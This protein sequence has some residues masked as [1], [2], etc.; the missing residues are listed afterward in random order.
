MKALMKPFIKRGRGTKQ[1]APYL[2]RHLDAEEIAN[3]LIETL[4]KTEAGISVTDLGVLVL[5]FVTWFM[6]ESVLARVDAEVVAGVEPRVGVEHESTEKPYSS[7]WLRSIGAADHETSTYAAN[8]LETTIDM[9]VSGPILRAKVRQKFRNTTQ[10]W[11]EGIYTFPLP[12]Q[13]AVDRL[14][15]VVGERVIE[16]QIHEKQ[17]AQRI[18]QKAR[19]TGKKTSLLSHHRSNI[20]TTSIA[21]ISPG[22]EVIVE[23]EY[24]QLLDFKDNRYALRFPMV[25]TP[26]YTP[27]R[28]R[29]DTEF[30]APLNVIRS[31][32]EAPGNPVTITVDLKAGF[33]IETLTSTSHTFKKDKLSEAHYKVSLAGRAQDS[34]RD[35]V[36]SWKL[37][38]SAEPMVR[39]LR[40]DVEGESY[41]LLMLMP[42]QLSGGPPN[43]EGSH[44]EE[45]EN[46][47]NE[48]EENSSE[49]RDRINR[50]LILV[51]DVS[52]SM[53]GESIEQARSAMLKAVSQLRPEDHFNIIYFNTRSWQLFP[54]SL[55][56]QESNLNFA[57]RSI[58]DQS[59]DGGT[60][61]RP[62][63]Q[64]GL[65]VAR[66]SERL[67]QVIFITDG[68]V[69][70]ETDL[71][72]EIK[73]HLGDSRLF[74]VGIGSAPNS[75]FMRKAALAG[76]GTFTYVSQAKDVSHKMN[77]LFR[78]LASPALTDLGFDINDPS[79]S[80]LPQ[81][82]PDLYLGEPVYVAFKSRNFPKFAELS[83]KLDG[84]PSSLRVS[85]QNPLR[86]DGVAVEWA[87]RK[88]TALQETYRE[89]SVGDYSS[90]SSKARKQ[91]IRNEIVDLAIFHHQVSKFTS[92]VTV[93]IDPEVSVRAGGLLKSHRTPANRPKGWV[94]ASS[95]ANKGIRLAQ[96]ATDA[97][98]RLLMGFMLLLGGLLFWLGFRSLQGRILCSGVCLKY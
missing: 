34:N 35:F 73:A 92:L 12:E 84:V 53:Q 9:T 68:A 26:Q 31:A 25:S 60:D 30:I 50:E 64:M 18:Y 81:P 40:E 59:A 88:I 89:A 51:L 98:Y 10:F 33:P 39:V 42:P 6:S 43:S 38:P 74:T 77:S 45:N 20:F 19:N 13:A 22:E 66:G 28:T 86:H 63:L 15:M 56:A 69:S 16:G 1:C 76:R 58:L 94:G 57:R 32:Q 17:S 11:S 93:D 29:L 37:K 96:T 87:R 90:L 95:S 67:R 70:N 27:A 83:G 62:A 71:F 49:E 7:L 85:L 23:F 41:G 46:E 82:L 2:I 47:E 75:Y 97:R 91:K 61:M 55:P 24:Q 79:A 21:N 65:N 3:N 52:G 5:L 72:S 48:N 78:K 54:Q 4:P 8:T 14:R 44:N 80:V 36:L